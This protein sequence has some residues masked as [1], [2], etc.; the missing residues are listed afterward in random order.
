MSLLP[1]ALQGHSSFS[2]VRPP[3][4]LPSFGLQLTCCLACVPRSRMQE[5]APSGSGTHCLCGSWAVVFTATP[6]CSAQVSIS[7]VSQ[8]S[9]HPIP[10]ARFSQRGPF[11]FFLQVQYHFSSISGVIIALKNSFSTLCSLCSPP[12][13]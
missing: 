1:A 9:R 13:F 7:V 10:A 8:D 12:Y 5:W 2:L 3:R 11:R 4:G 6:S